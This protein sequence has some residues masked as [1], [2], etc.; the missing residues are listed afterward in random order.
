MG[1]DTRTDGC[2]DGDKG[3]DD[4][5][6]GSDHD[7]GLSSTGI[8]EHTRGCDGNEGCDHI[9]AGEQPGAAEGS[10]LAVA[11]VPGRGGHGGMADGTGLDGNAEGSDDN[12]GSNIQD[13]DTT[14]EVVSK[15]SA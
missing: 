3:C 11:R 12:E 4:K 14:T 6:E 15:T 1:L 13:H 9:D 8:D 10:I 7:K 2:D 5:I